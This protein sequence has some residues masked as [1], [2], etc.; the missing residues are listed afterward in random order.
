MTNQNAIKDRLHERLGELRTLRDEIRL[1]VHL[2]SMELRDEWRELERKL[3][4]PEV[5]AEQIQKGAKEAIDAL[6]AQLQGFR[7]RLRQHAKRP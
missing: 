5:A 3:P 6:A 1:D 7:A 2:A 4:E